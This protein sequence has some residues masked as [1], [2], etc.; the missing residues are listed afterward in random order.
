[1]LLI[2]LP[3]LSGSAVAQLNPI[4]GGS[5]NYARLLDKPSQFQSM[6]EADTML[7][8]PAIPPLRWHECLTNIPADMWEMGRISISRESLLPL[9]GIGVMTAAL[10]MTDD[11]TYTMSSRIYRQSNVGKT[12]SDIF[13]SLGDGKSQFGMAGIFGVYGLIAGDDHALRTGSQII[14]VVLGAGFVVQILK[15]MTGRE[16]PFVATEP[17]GIW[18]FFPNQIDYHKHVPH[19]DAFPSGHLCTSVATVVVIAENYPDVKW[20]R[21]VGYTIAGLVGVGMVNYGIHWYSDYPLAVAIGY[22]FGMIAAHP[23]IYR[24]D[25]N[26]PQAVVLS[27]SPVV[28]RYGAGMGLK[29]RF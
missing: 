9:A 1:M 24:S 6:L 26:D 12:W 25:N 5:S 4:A 22:V 29:M 8:A 18:R 2:C 23:E 11:I 21:P 28:S 14:E 13:V 17:T 20:I 10:T 7:R 15:H 3:L 19:Y 27:M 16:S